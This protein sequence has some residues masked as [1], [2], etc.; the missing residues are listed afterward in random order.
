VREGDTVKAIATAL[1]VSIEQLDDENDADLET[2]SQPQDLV[3]CAS[4]FE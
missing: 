2:P 4:W 3:V 1:G